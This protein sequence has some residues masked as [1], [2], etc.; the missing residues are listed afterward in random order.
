MIQTNIRTGY[1]RT[2]IFDVV[3][4]AAAVRS[5]N[6]RK[7]RRKQKKQK[8]STASGGSSAKETKETLSF[9]VPVSSRWSKQ[10]VA[11]TLVNITQCLSLKRQAYQE[12]THYTFIAS[13]V[14]PVTKSTTYGNTM[15]SVTDEYTTDAVHRLTHSSTTNEA[16]HQPTVLAL[17]FA[18]S[19]NVGGGFHHRKGTQE[20]SLFRCTSLFLSLYQHRRVDD[21]RIHPIGSMPRSES[22]YPHT[23]CGGI[24]TPRVV[25]RAQHG[26]S[27]DEER[28]FAIFSCAAQDLRFKTPPKGTKSHDA[29]LLSEKVRTVFHVAQIHGHK[30]LVL[31]A[32]GCGAFLGEGGPEKKKQRRHATATT[33]KTLLQGEFRNV[34]DH[35]VFAIPNVES[36]NHQAFLQVFEE[37]LVPA[38]SSSS[39]ATSSASSSSSSSSWSSKESKTTTTGGSGG[40]GGGSGGCVCM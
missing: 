14:A 23:E 6:V 5:S 38:A 39:S 12:A 18:N 31:G 34:F 40:S 24:Y 7:K 22:F 27:F 26:N 19:Y 35:V 8:K 20:E 15:I 3:D 16:T 4:R 9:S 13:R 28:P 1:E 32:F 11:A 29:Q 17:N 37:L 25:Q 30:R 10:A 2:I 21:E 33:F 36:D